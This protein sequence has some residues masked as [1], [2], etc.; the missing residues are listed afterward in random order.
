LT[1]LDAAPS[2]GFAAGQITTMHDEPVRIL[3]YQDS[4]GGLSER[5]ACDCAF[6]VSRDRSQ[7]EAADAIVF[8]LPRLRE[9]RFP[10]RKRAGQIWV[11]LCVESA[12]HYPMLAGR[13]RLGAVFDL[14][15]TYQR[16]ADVWCPYFGR[17][18]V[19]ALS[20][21][22]LDKT[23][24]AP[25]VAF[26]SSGHDASGRGA[27]LSE[28]MRHMP[29]DSYGKLH[30]NRTLANDEGP[31]SKRSAIA[32]Y[33]FTLAFEN[34]IDRDY[35]TEKFFDPLYA[36][37]VPVYLGAPN[38]EAFAPG[39]DCFIDAAHYD[40]PRALAQHLMELAAD[41]AAYARYLRWKSEP[42][43]AS[44]LGMVEE[45]RDSTLCR[46]ARLVRRSREQSA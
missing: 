25:A 10:P 13:A 41:E 31:A 21:K 22:P 43:R 20:S 46:L 15:M 2:S 24:P 6:E 39:D 4:W 18:V 17:N 5:D 16:D 32:R 19:A 29:V 34:A 37:S 36:G 14:W 3:I 26:I 44:F 42:L 23:E 12:V 11:A 45:V 35:V 40:G 27:F 9:S 1:L 8:H 28:L 7:W 38:V 30:R 33:R